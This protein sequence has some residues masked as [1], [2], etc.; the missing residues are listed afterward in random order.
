M[1]PIRDPSQD[2]RPTDTESEGLETNFQANG[3]EKKTGV[4]ILIPGKID[5]KRRAIRRDPEGH[6][7]ILKERIHQEDLTL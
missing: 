6:I 5:F 4:A 3:Q 7:I 1:L 2:K